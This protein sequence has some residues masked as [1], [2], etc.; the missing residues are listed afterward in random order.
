MGRSDGRHLRRVAAPRCLLQAACCLLLLPAAGCVVGAPGNLGAG[1]PIAPNGNLDA[2]PCHDGVCA[3]PIMGSGTSGGAR[4]A[5]T[6]GPTGV[7]GPA[8]GGAVPEAAGARCGRC[9]HWRPGLARQ[10]LAAAVAAAGYHNQPR[11]FPVP[12][13]PVF[14]A[15]SYSPSVNL[16]APEGG[17]EGPF[18][19]EP[20][21]VPAPAPL[22][23]LGS[24]DPGTSTAE[25]AAAPGVVRDDPSW[26]FQAPGEE[27]LKA[28]RQ[29]QADTSRPKRRTYQ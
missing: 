13:Q 7:D 29:A 26:M 28:A 11:F 5:T 19:P 1:S 8:V 2:T 9:G 20:E 22:P 18:T 16:G 27:E 4:P 25:R 3:G 21:V 24:S 10:R 23:G 17:N 15:R 6:E 12:T 14:L